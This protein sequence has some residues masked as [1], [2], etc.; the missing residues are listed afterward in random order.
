[1]IKKRFF[2]YLTKKKQIKVYFCNTKK[3]KIL[4]KKNCPTIGGTLVLWETEKQL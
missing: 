3:I 2:L 1:M 4:T